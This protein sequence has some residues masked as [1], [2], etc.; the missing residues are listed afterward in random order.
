MQNQNTL[1]SLILLAGSMFQNKAYRLMPAYW[2]MVPVS[3][4]VNRYG[5]R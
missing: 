4:S 1:Q 3:H 5:I 2:A